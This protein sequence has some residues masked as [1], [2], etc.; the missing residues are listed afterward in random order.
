MAEQEPTIG[1]VLRELRAVESRLT[2]R[3]DNVESRLTKLIE[4]KWTD[5]VARATGGDMRIHRRLTG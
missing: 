3:I 1:D 2:T 5:A 4:D